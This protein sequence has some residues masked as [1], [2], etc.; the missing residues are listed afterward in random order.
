MD[1]VSFKWNEKKSKTNFNKHK[2]TFDE[3][4][5][6]FFDSNARI[7]FDPDHSKDEDRFVLLGLS[8]VLRLLVVCHCCR[9]NNGKIIR[10]ISARKANKQEQKQYESF[11]P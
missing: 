3:A 8:S 11:L 2:V 10:I 9:E 4:Q 1:F 6:A 7:I 5:T